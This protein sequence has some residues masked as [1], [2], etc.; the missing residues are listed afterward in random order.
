MDNLLHEAAHCPVCDREP[1]ASNEQ[2]FDS[3]LVFL[4]CPGGHPYVACG[5]DLFWAVRHWDE[6]IALRVQA[7]TKN[8]V[9]TIAKNVNSS[10]CRSC[11]RYTKSTT[12]VAKVQGRY[13]NNYSCAVAT[14][15]CADCHLIK[16]EKECA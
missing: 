6:Y 5:D 11:Q 12:T 13:E 1:V 2:G 8:M 7:D 14:H 4:R 9:R 10:W 15:Q 16:Q 3:M